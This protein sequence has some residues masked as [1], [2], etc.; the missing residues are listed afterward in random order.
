VGLQFLNDDFERTVKDV[1]QVKST[2][3]FSR[4]L[5]QGLQSRHLLLKTEGF[6]ADQ[7]WSRHCGLMNTRHVSYLDCG[8]LATVPVAVDEAFNERRYHLGFVG[9]AH[10][11]RRSGEDLI[12]LEGSVANS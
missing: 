11:A 5:K 2:M 7:F 8:R 3:H 10:Y 6:G 1:I 12:N 4:S 9:T